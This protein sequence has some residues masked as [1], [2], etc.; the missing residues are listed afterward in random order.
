MSCVACDQVTK[1]LASRALRDRPTVSYLGDTVRLSYAENPGAFL[2][3]GAEFP[4]WLRACLFGGLTVLTIALL[5]TGVVRVPSAT[6]SQLLAVGLIIA[7]GIGNLVDRL[8]FGFVRDFLNVGVGQLRT[9][10]FNVADAAVMAGVAV[11]CVIS[12]RKPTS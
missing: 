7:G 1:E 9:G 10:I 4:S 6:F 8:Q 3:F 11:L 2:S 12:L 5:M